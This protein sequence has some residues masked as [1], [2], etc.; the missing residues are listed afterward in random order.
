MSMAPEENPSA[1]PADFGEKV[2][3]SQLI[4]S[5]LDDIR[6]DQDIM[7]QEIDGLRQEIKQEVNGLRQEIKQEVNGLR[8][9][10]KQEVNGLRQE[11]KQEISGLRYWTGGGIIAVLLAT[12]TI[13]LTLKA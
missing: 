1:L 7:R 10:I 3:I 5:R 12:V 2:S 13:I 6:H 4:L 11:I 8:Q 9:E